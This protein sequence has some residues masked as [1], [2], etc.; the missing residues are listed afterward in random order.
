M[1]ILSPFATRKQARRKILF[2]TAFVSRHFHA[3]TCYFQFTELGFATRAMKNTIYL[4]FAL[5]TTVVTCC[6]AVVTGDDFNANTAAAVATLQSWYNPTNGLWSN[7]WWNS[8]NCVE[9]LENEIA[10]NNDTKYL[11]TLQNTF[12][13]NSSGNFINSYY[14]DEGWWVNAWVRAYDLTGNASYLNMAKTIFADMTGGWDTTSCNGGLWWSKS[15]T[16]KNAIANELFLLG[17]IRL[18]QRTPGD[19]GASGSYLY[20]ATNEWTWFKSSGMINAQNLINDGLDSNC[21]NNGQTTWSYNQGVILGGLTDLFKATGNT[22]YLKQAETLANATIGLLVSTSAS[23]PKGVLQEPGEANGFGGTDV[24]EFKGIF[25][26]NLAYLYD[27][28]HSAAYFNFF[29]TNAHSIWF[30]NRNLTGTGIATNQLGLRWTGTFDSADAARQSSA[31]MPASVLAEPVTSLLS[32]AKSA[33]DPAFNHTVGMATG[34]LAWAVS[35]TITANAGLIQSGP[36]IT[37]LPT[38]SHTAHFRMAVTATSNSNSNLVSLIVL[39]NGTLIASASGLWNSFIA[40]NQPQDFPVTFTNTIAGGALEFRVFWNQVP[41]A[42]TV[43][44]SDTTID[45]FHNWT[46]ANLA[47]DLGRLDGLNGWEADPLRDIASGYLAKGPDTAEL[48]TGSYTANFELKVDNFNWDNSLVATLTVVNVDANTV[49]ATRSVARTEF[50]NTLYQTFGLSFRAVA[51]THYDFRTYWN[52]AA[53][54]PRLTQR[55]LVV[56]PQGVS[57]F[58][59]ITLKPGSYN[60]DVVIEHTAP[61]VPSGHYT[62]ASM[63]NGLANTA[64]SWYERGYD[65][66]A[67]TTGLPVAGSTITNQSASDHSYTFAASYAANNVAY[68][69]ATHTANIILA[70]P[71][72]FLALSFLTAAGHGPVTVDYQVNHAD[73]TSESGKL[74]APD[75]FFNAPVAWNAQGRVDVGSGNFNSVNNNNPILYAK[76]ITLTNTSST[77][78]NLSLN[79]DSS[80][81]SGSVATVFAVS[82]FISRIAAPQISVVNLSSGNLQIQFQSQS[83]ATYT[84]QSVTNLTVPVY[85]GNLS[86]NI[87]SG[88]PINLTVPM[89]SGSD[90][91]Y[92]RILAN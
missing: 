80:N 4:V 29:Y 5:F 8:A 60:Q 52:Y 64:N 10:A 16:Y 37:Y 17:A 15:K 21:A 41:A 83:G 42:P 72:K 77:V 58:T 25:A 82:G 34:A 57:G 62:T 85:W 88:N 76:D 1:N 19:T 86:T 59:S 24:P 79:W 33:G 44:L 91:Q 71:D 7:L 14:D 50:A 11:A 6:G 32:F 69:D 54:A 49:V 38:G 9:A 43:T 28:D 30:N 61:T 48:F 81:G 3:H 2:N 31:I 70:A 35:P 89:N 27:V 66:A 65:A 78:T 45:G 22:N 18:H 12:A 39:Q 67:P 20:W 92:F 73:R 26:R 87:G 51:G 53:N 56:A 90:Q 75:W 84:L 47:H 46:A 23:L 13:M 63:D 40:A 68:V 74:V 55:S 36:F